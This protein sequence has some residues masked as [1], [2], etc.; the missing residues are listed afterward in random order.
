MMIHFWGVSRLD[1]SGMYR[2]GVQSDLGCYVGLLVGWNRVDHLIRD[3]IRCWFTCRSISRLDV[4]LSFGP[5]F[6]GAVVEVALP[7]YTHL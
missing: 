1:G 2:H 5:N 4:G 3:G 6:S 7:E